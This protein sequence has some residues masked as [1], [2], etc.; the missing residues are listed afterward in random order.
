MKKLVKSAT[1]S[2]I[3][4]VPANGAFLFIAHAWG[5]WSYFL[6]IQFCLI[7]INMAKLSKSFLG[8]KKKGKKVGPGGEASSGGS[9]A[10]SGVE[11]SGNDSVFYSTA[12]A[13]KT[14]ETTVETESGGK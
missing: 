1:K 3:I 8:G 14:S 4:N 10:G 7:P 5:F 12:Q 2:A 11:P 9:S 6:P 13:S